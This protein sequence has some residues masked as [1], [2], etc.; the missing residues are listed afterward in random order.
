MQDGALGVGDEPTA[1]GPDHSGP[2][3]RMSAAEQAGYIAQLCAGL[4]TM[5]RGRG[6]AVLATLLGMA[7]T[8]AVRIAREGSS[9]DDG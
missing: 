6:E 4:A 7:Q 5:A 3:L 9:D 8:E 2:G 1:S